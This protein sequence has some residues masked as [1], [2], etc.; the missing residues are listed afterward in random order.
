M[1]DAKLREALRKVND[2]QHR[3]A[4]ELDSSVNQP[5]IEYYTRQMEDVIVAALAAPSEPQDSEPLPYETWNTER[6]AKWIVETYK[7]EDLI[8]AI[9]IWIRRT[10]WRVRRQG[11]NVRL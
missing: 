3:M 8:K 11:F 2:L 1:S 7:G 6:V 5:R 9:A 4:I 10:R